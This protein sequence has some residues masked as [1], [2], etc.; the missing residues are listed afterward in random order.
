MIV[1][2]TIS[3]DTKKDIL[4]QDYIKLDQTC[5]NPNENGYSVTFTS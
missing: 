1:C 4:Q 3:P 5:I 2:Y